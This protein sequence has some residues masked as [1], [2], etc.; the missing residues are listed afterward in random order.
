ML[1]FRHCGKNDAEPVVTE[2]PLLTFALLKD[3][4]DA[5]KFVNFLK[6]KTNFVPSCARLGIEATAAILRLRQPSLRMT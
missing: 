3:A 4:T 2:H 5:R 6:V 1:S